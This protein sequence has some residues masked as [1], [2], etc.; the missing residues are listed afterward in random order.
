[1][2]IASNHA[3]DDLYR[4]ETKASGRGEFYARQV[5]SS[6]NY[7]LGNDVVDFLHGWL[8]YQIEHHLFPDL[9]MLKYQQIQPKVKE[10]CERYGL[11]YVQEGV[12][13]RARRLL[14]IMVGKTSMK[15]VERVAKTTPE[16]AAAQAAE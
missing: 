15:R 13:K 7:G 9:P 4:F 12:F 11:P 8:N 2:V 10:V 5:L 14:D 16:S 6:V 3:G 1:V